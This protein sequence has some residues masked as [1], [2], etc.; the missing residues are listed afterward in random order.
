MFQNFK[1]LLHAYILFLSAD[2]IDYMDTYMIISVLKL[3]VKFIF[4]VI[5]RNVT[6][7]S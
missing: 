7:T 3:P 6:K 5:L 1:A 4:V 2:H